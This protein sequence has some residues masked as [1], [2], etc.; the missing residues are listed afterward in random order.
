MTRGVEDLH[1]AY[2]VPVLQGAVDGAGRMTVQPQ[3][4]GNLKRV[5]S[6]V[7]GVGTQQQPWGCLGLAL[8]GDD[9]RL[10]RM[11][12]DGRPAHALEFGQPAEVRAVGVSQQDM[13]Q[14]VHR[15]TYAFYLLQHEP[16][17]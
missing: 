4:E 11:G 9:V 5:H 15:A 7:A 12:V 3:G 14:V 2:P 13:L 8:S 16:G 1:W 17:I 6:Q 10:P